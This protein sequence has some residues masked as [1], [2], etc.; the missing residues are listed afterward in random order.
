MTDVNIREAE[1]KQQVEVDTFNMMQYKVQ[2]FSI[3]VFLV[4]VAF[5]ALITKM[6]CY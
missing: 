6:P 3:L 1:I 4:V 2:N 5:F